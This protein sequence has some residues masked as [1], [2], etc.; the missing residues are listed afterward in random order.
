VNPRSLA[1]DRELQIVELLLQTAIVADLPKRPE[2]R[3]VE[4]VLV[5]GVGTQDTEH[6]VTHN[7]PE[8]VAASPGGHDRPTTQQLLNQRFGVV[9]RLARRDW[10][11]R[12]ALGSPC[13]A[14]TIA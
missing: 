10:S 13:I 8:P 11:H 5:G 2:D 12:H 6:T 14:S 7:P 9:H 1:P 3:L 4:L